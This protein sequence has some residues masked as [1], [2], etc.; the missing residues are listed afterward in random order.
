MIINLGDL[1]RAYHARRSLEGR[2]ALRRYLLDGDEPTAAVFILVSRRLY[3]EGLIDN[4]GLAV[5]WIAGVTLA[6]RAALFSAIA[7]G[8]LR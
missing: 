1:Q 5:Q 3:A 4:I 6:E 7:T 8:L 2:D